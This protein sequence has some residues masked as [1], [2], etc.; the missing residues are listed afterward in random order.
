R[1][2]ERGAGQASEHG[3]E[4]SIYGCDRRDGSAGA[5][6]TIRR[7]KGGGQSNRERLSNRERSQLTAGR[8]RLTLSTPSGQLTAVRQRP[9]YRSDHS[10]YPVPTRLAPLCVLRASWRDG[11]F[12]D[13]SAPTAES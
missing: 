6:A 2:Q 10:A 3:A 4:A 1:Y 7:M 13:R 9:H 8:Q 11:G 12:A 5:G